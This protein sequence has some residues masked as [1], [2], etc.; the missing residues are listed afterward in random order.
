MK[1]RY[2]LPF[3]FSALLF[4]C[5]DSEILDAN[6]ANNAASIQLSN[7]LEFPADD[8][9]LELT[10]TEGEKVN[11]LLKVFGANIPNAVYSQSDFN[12]PTEEQLAVIKEEADKIVKDCNTTYEKYEALYKWVHEN[13]EYNHSNTWVSNSAW[14]TFTKRLAIC[15]GYA[16]LLNA[17]LYTQDIVNVLANGKY[18]SGEQVY[19]HAWNY[20]KVD[21][22]W[23]LS[24]ATN[25]ISHKA[26]EPGYNFIPTDLSCT[27]C[28]D[29]HFIYNYNRGEINVQ[30]IKDASEQLVVPFSVSGYKV[31]KFKPTV[32]W[33]NTGEVDPY[34][35]PIFKSTKFD[36]VTDLY[37]GKNIKSI[38]S[39]EDG[40]NTEL[41]EIFPN[42]KN[43]YVDPENTSLTSKTGVIY[44]IENG[45]Y[46][47]RAI[48][49]KVERIELMPME[50]VDKECNLSFLDELQVLVLDAS[51]YLL[52]STSII[53]CPKLYEV[54]VPAGCWIE[55]MAIYKNGDESNDWANIDCNNTVN[56]I[57]FTPTSVEQIKY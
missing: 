4:S 48:A 45:K 42:L 28:E 53:G 30:A 35:S 1:L 8:G 39:F 32:L 43:I 50:I 23:Y 47:V 13:V 16:E 57:E 46:I 20:V 38:A 17:M 21:D 54:H 19:G 44:T 24:D 11:T 3:I 36:T 2:T 55:D 25:L 5:N 27:L 41:T 6:S 51:T 37:I 29:D 10:G 12:K 15:Q 14:D 22:T 56:F 52:A 18:K 33:I 26:S 9:A 34:G 49:P 31:T 40:E 7:Q